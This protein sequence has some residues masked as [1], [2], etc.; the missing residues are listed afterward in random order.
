M[1]K[2]SFVVMVAG[3]VAIDMQAYV[4]QYLTRMM[5]AS[6]RNEGCLIY[7]VHQ[8]ASNDC[9][10][11]MYSEWLDKDAFERHNKSGEMQEF[12]GELAKAMF[13][14]RSPKTFWRTLS[15]SGE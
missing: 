13:D 11:M 12:I 1:K 3:V 6:R 4:K 2:G 14:V 8:S 15:E 7:N 5:L 9:E 10:F